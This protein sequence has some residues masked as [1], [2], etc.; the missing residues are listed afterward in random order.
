MQFVVI[1]IIATVV[2]LFVVLA[3]GGVINSKEQYSCSNCGYVFTQKWYSLMWKSGPMVKDGNG[4]LRLKCPSCKK[5]DFC[6]H[7][8]RTNH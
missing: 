5:V 8:K 3:V 6:Q 1:T 7:T 4:E 2:V